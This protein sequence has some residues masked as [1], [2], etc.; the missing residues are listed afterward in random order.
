[1]FRAAAVAASIATT[2]L[3]P[4]LAHADGGFYLGGGV[5]RARLEVENVVSTNSAAAFTGEGNTTAWKVYGGWKAPALFGVEGGYYD[6]G[7]LD[8]G[9]VNIASSSLKMSGLGAFGTLTLGI[10][11]LPVEFIGKLGA[12]WWDGKLDVDGS[13]PLAGTT[14]RRDKSAFAP[15]GGIGVQVGL[16][17]LKARAEFERIESDSDGFKP[18]NLFTV[19]LNYTF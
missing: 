19:S 1:M 13:G 12:V 16:F 2:L 4:T 10:P 6:F 8:G 11:L 3:L 5:G 9:G 14:V 7:K 18:V 17:G 15:A